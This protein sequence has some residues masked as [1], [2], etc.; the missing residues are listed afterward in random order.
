VS[1][2]ADPDRVYRLITDIMLMLQRLKD[3]AE[4]G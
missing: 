1:I 3:K 2:K 4:A